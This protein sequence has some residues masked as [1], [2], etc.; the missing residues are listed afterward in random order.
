MRTWMGTGAV[1]IAMLALPVAALGAQELP[2]GA[3]GGLE[4]RTLYELAFSPADGMLG[5]ATHYGVF[6]YTVPELEQTRSFPLSGVAYSL[7]FS[8]DGAYLAAGTF[9]QVV[10]WDYETGE[11]AASHQGGSAS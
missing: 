10:V 11:P 8:P 1:L 9:S 6:I 3:V 2:P 4:L 5:V 7:A